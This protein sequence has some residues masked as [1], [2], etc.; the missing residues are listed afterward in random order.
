[1][2]TLSA[3]GHAVL[4]TNYRCRYGEVD[5][6]TRDGGDIVFVEVRTKTT[7]AYGSPA[8]S[9]T[10]RKKEKLRELAAHYLQDHEMSVEDYRIDA[11]LVELARNRSVV[12][13]HIRHAVED[14][15]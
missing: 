5:I 3:R 7:T 4:E 12:I 9:I 13:T 11:V 1:M 2:N 15:T 10:A 14:E 6:I 8:E